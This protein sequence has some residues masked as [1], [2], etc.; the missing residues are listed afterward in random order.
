MSAGLTYDKNALADFCAKFPLRHFK[1]GRPLL[2]QGEV[3]QSMFFIKEG[4]VKLYNITAGGEEK[5]IGYEAAGGLLPIAWL[6]NRSSVSTY[7][8]DTFTDSQLYAV[9]KADLLDFVAIRSDLPA[10][11]LDNVVTMYIGSTLHLHALEQSKAKDKLLYIFQYLVL[12]FGAPAGKDLSKI[13]LKLTH[14]DIANL[15]GIT[16]ETA[17]TEIGKLSKAG[18]I[19]QSSPHYIIDTN[20]ALRQLGESEFEELKI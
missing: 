20:K 17:S 13:N 11:L 19:K 2:Y 4:V 6:F 9:P 15:I 14:Q 8:Y 1:K 3:P 16:R 12:R 18:I 10:L 7:Y 5:T